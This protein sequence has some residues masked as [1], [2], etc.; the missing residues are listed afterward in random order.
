MI[1]TAS[2]TRSNS[3]KS[4]HRRMARPCMTVINGSHEAGMVVPCL[5]MIPPFALT[6]GWGNFSWACG[7][8][9]SCH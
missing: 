8:T 7:Q 5:E 9:A 3:Y 2:W 6:R 1:G 4:K